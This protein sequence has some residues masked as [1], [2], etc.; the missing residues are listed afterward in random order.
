MLND[1]FLFVTVIFSLYLNIKIDLMQS[2]ILITI[3]N[4]YKYEQKHFQ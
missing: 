2:H 3:F 1:K 4:L